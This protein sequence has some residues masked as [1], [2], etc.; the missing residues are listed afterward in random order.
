MRHFVVV[1]TVS[2]AVAVEAE[3][4][5][6]ALSAAEQIPEEYWEYVDHEMSVEELSDEDIDE[7]DEKDDE[8]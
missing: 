2:Y 8:A 5:G 3:T 6:E 4:V 7:V 1:S